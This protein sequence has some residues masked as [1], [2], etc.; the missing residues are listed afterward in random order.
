M[1]TPKEVRYYPERDGRNYITPEDVQAAIDAGAER[2]ELQ[3][4]VL[5]VLGGE[6]GAEDGT[7]CA[8]V[9]ARFERS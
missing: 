2:A 4:E 1:R 6:M 5:E 3:Q 8:F 9:A 7:C